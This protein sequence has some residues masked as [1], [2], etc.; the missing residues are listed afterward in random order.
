MSFVDYFKDA[1][2][3]AK[4]AQSVELQRELLEMRDA[5]NTLV[6]ENAGLRKELHALKEQQ[7]KEL[8]VRYR[9]NTV[10]SSAPDGT[11]DGPFCARCWDV[12]RRLVHVQVGTGQW[13]NRFV[14]CEQCDLERARR[15]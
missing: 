15:R 3:I 7:Q 2:E 1:W 10:F 11:E 5:Y 8:S 4:K 12:D 14:S 13:G 6:E 9:D